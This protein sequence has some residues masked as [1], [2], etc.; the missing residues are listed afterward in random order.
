MIPHIDNISLFVLFLPIHKHLKF[1]YHLNNQIY[2]I[3]LMSFLYHYFQFLNR[4]A[5]NVHLLLDCITQFP[6]FIHKMIVLYF[7]L[8]HILYQHQ[9]ISYSIQ[10]LILIQVNL[11][12]FQASIEIFFSQDPALISLIYRSKFDLTVY[13]LKKS[14]YLI[15]LDLLTYWFSS[16]SLIW[17]H[18]ACLSTLNSKGTME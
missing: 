4:S 17:N 15:L 5:I 14:S 13:N 8:P 7:K 16:L 12:L 11:I 9:N 3:E 6:S 2:Y 18:Q 1:S 10:C